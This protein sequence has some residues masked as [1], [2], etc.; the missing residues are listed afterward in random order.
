MSKARNL[1]D[2]ISD[3]T[4]D[5]TEIADG[6]VTAAKLHTSLDLSS[7]TVTFADDHISGNKIHGGVISG[8]ASTGI[9]DNASSTA[10]TI[11]SSGNVG[12]GT[13]SPTQK[14]DV[15]GNASFY[16][17]NI[18]V[19]AK[20]SSGSGYAAF[21]AAGSNGTSVLDIGVETSSGGGLVTGS[22]AHSGIV[23]T[24]NNYPLAFA[25]NSTERVRIGTDGS[26]GVGTSAPN[27]GASGLHSVGPFIQGA[28][29]LYQQQIS[30]NSGNRI[31][32]LV[33]GV[34]YSSL[35]LNELGGNVGIG[36]DSPSE[37][38]HVDSATNTR[39]RISTTNT[40]AVPEI[41]LYNAAKEWKIGVETSTDA[42]G[43]A[44]SNAGA[45]AFVI[46]NQT[47]GITQLV[48]STGG[49]VHINRDLMPMTTSNGGNT[50]GLFEAQSTHPQ[51][52]FYLPS[53]HWGG[54]TVGRTY[55]AI[56]N[57]NSSSF[58][59]G[60]TIV[61]IIVHGGG[62]NSVATTYAT[63]MLSHYRDIL[64]TS[65]TLYYSDV[66]IKVTFNSGN[67]CTIWVAAN[68]YNNNTYNTYVEIQ[69]KVPLKITMDPSSTY[70]DFYWEHIASDGVQTSGEGNA[71]T[72]SGP[73][74][75]TGY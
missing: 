9:D 19:V 73:T 7:K 35:L 65:R 58:G 26:V 41:Q 23:S 54:T 44:Y 18:N 62:G 6:A 22:S 40:G 24:R 50:G 68:W 3:A 56:C 75:M 5:A 34:G 67:D 14:L 33:L 17:S 57:I 38:L 72:G 21:V 51:R 53:Y 49:D 39:L 11:D 52:C 4:I 10:V 28:S 47:D 70:S 63:I 12:V 8:F 31:Q 43:G 64:I 27:C 16:A 15:R 2:F 45:S 37:L 60:R 48:A 1:S 20:D 59:H 25:T 69:P 13:A 61:D 36:T 71:Y 32:S 42:G 30:I 46:R 29:G 55:K 66:G 74:T